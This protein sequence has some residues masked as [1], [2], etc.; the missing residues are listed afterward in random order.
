[1]KK[2]TFFIA[3]LI[4]ASLSAQVVLQ[5]FSNAKNAANKD[6]Y[7]VF[8]G[9]LS[10]GLVASPTD[11]SN[12]VAEA[13]NSAGGDIW[14]GMFTRPQTHYI[15]LTSNQSI[16]VNV[17]STTTAYFKGK[18]QAGLTGQS[19]IELTTA[20]T[21]NGTGWETLTFTFTGATGEWE[22]FVVFTNVNSSGSFV[23]P[24]VNADT[25]YFDN[26]SAMQGSAIPIPT[27]PTDSP[28]APTHASSDVIS[29]FSDATGY[30][31]IV[32]NFNPGWAQATVPDYAYDPG[33]GNNLGQLAGLN[34]QGMD[35]TSTSL[36][37][38]TYLHIDVWASTSDRMLKVTPILNG[39]TTEFLV[40]VP[41]TANAWNSVDIPLSDFTGL[42]FSTNN[43]V[44]FKFDGQFNS[45]GSANTSG[46]DVYFDNLYFHN[47]ALSNEEFTAIEFKI[48]P[49]PTNNNWNIRSNS[50]INSVNVYD[51]LGKQVITL[52]PDNNET[53]INAS[54]LNTGVY[55]AK[56]EG[57][58]GSKTIKLVKN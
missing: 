33:D 53:T 30:S 9:G 44:Q 26:V 12:Q 8:G 27:G 36:A 29:L 47:T 2:I 17:Y 18:I 20:E 46:W 39:G 21:H 16:S 49:N 43:I 15:D 32:S 31:T 28:A 6:T 13:A 55:L 22:E 7:G 19:A 14:K 24:A 54:T 4:S 1:M 37:S 42:D 52:K 41:I 58:N 38:M 40:E 57:I 10:G 50:I 35:I 5:D 48:F 51:I 11:A 56:I 25:F 45:D 3:V 23:D 34:Y